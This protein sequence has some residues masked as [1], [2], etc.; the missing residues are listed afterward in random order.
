MDRYKQKKLAQPKSYQ[1]HKGHV[2][3]RLLLFDHTFY[4]NFTFRANRLNDV[5]TIW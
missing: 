1:L 2:Q 5:H 3:F 4:Q